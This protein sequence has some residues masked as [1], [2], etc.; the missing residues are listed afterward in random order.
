MQDEVR[1]ITISWKGRGG[2]LAGFFYLWNERG[3]GSDGV[4]LS[5]WKGMK[6]GGGG[7]AVK[8]NGEG[9]DVNGLIVSALHKRIESLAY[10]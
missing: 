10:V 3:S 5:F 2:I 4:S 9:C 1:I 6:K 8:V 7:G